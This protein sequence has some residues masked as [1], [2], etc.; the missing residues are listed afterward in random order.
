MKPINEKLAK[1]KNR[2][3]KP[4][5]TTERTITKRENDAIPVLS[6]RYLTNKLRF[7]NQKINN[8]NIHT[9]EYKDLTEQINKYEKELINADIKLIK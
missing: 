3:A 8:T 6:I 9:K 1:Q 7:L 2:F 4:M 5:S